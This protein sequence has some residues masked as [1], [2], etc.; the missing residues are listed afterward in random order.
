MERL[1]VYRGIITRHVTMAID[2]T[3]GGTFVKS[4]SAL[5]LAIGTSLCIGACS[6]GPSSEEIRELAALES[7]IAALE[8][9]KSLIEDAN[10]IKRLQRA[11]GYYIDEA[12]WDE[13]ADLFAEDGTIEIGLDGVYVGKARVREYLYA[14]G[15]G[16]HGLL[17]G[18]INEH[19]Q[20]MP[21]VTVAPDG[22][23]AKARW[24]ALIMAGTLGEN[25]IWGEGPYENE[26]VKED[27]VWKI[28]TLHWYQSMV[29][30]YEGGWQ[31]NADVNG[32]KW[33][34]STLP[35]D[36][37]PSVE[38]KTWPDVYVPPFHFPNPVGKY[39]AAGEAGAQ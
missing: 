25:A 34:S 10:D 26:Y 33:V 13:V 22:R 20:L 21:V 31:P 2:R 3:T 18:Q 17:Y 9:R 6:K 12:Q 38:Y 27:G 30:P 32:G 23:T 29:V 35:P 5:C 16:R 14:L 7:Q 39:V 19:F 36:R 1:H 37:P 28:K 15:G 11:Y 24:R 8:Q 4:T